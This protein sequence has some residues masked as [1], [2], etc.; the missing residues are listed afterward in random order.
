MLTVISQVITK[1]NKRKLSEITPEESDTKEIKKEKSVQPKRYYTLVEMS[2]GQKKKY[3]DGT[4]DCN[5]CEES[6]TLDNFYKYDELSYAV[7]GGCRGCY[8]DK[9]EALEDREDHEIIDD[10]EDLYGE[11]YEDAMLKCVLCDEPKNLL[12]DFG[13]N[14]SVLHGRSEECLKCEKLEACEEGENSEE[15]YNVCSAINGPAPTRAS[16]ELIKKINNHISQ[17][18][19]SDGDHVVW[20]KKLK[21][22]YPKFKLEEKIRAVSAWY[23][24]A[25][26]GELFDHLNVRYSPTCTIDGC[27]SHSIPLQKNLTSMASFTEYDYAHY[28][29]MLKKNSKEVGNCVLWTGSCNSDGYGNCHYPPTVYHPHVFSWMLANKKDIPEGMLIR[30]NCRNRS[31]LKI[32]HLELGDA[33]DNAQ[34]RKRDGTQ[35]FGENCSASKLTNVQVLE[36]INSLGDGQTKKKR[37]E[38]YGVGEIAIYNI[39][40]TIKWRHLMT[41]DQLKIRDNNLKEMRKKKRGNKLKM[42]YSIAEEMRKLFRETKIDRKNLALKFNVSRDVIRNVL[43]NK[44]W[45]KPKDSKESWTKYFEKSRQRIESHVDKITD[46]AGETHW[47][48]N[49]FYNKGYGNCAFNGR[50]MGAHVASYMAFNEVK[51]ID[52]ECIRHRCLHKGCVYPPHLLAG[53][54]KQNGEDT[55]TD[56]TSTRG[57]NHGNCKISQEVALQIKKSRGLG[58]QLDRAKKF[59]VSIR[60]VHNID[61]GASWGWLKCD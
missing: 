41:P 24:I 3:P 55:I 11:D 44:S 25:K 22:G 13:E 37:G 50:P 33:A 1:M 46:D 38:K 6:L 14:H 43:D 36:I 59:D 60:V 10:C 30:H 26:T 31:C 42:S 52:W 54:N 39:D 48:W 32:E 28:R 51:E 15:K 19:K 17:H 40:Y 53:T 29:G 7:S 61:F 8:G 4:K 9:W 34:D 2:R 35:K 21:Y 23:H 58:T 56:G 18:G 16:K 5:N 20:S 47:I 49:A 27:I 57:V 45:T 12:Y